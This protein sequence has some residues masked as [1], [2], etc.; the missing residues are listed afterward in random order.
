MQGERA[1]GRGQ[2][3]PH[4][5]MHSGGKGGERTIRRKIVVKDARVE[6]RRGEGERDEEGAEERE[7]EHG[8]VRGRGEGRS[9][10]TRG[11]RSSEKG[12]VK[13]RLRAGER[14]EGRDVVWSPPLRVR[15]S[16]GRSGRLR[17]TDLKNMIA[18]EL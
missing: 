17:R 16:L 7:A 14:E 13:E 1:K 8:A 18:Y 10:A 15:I 3:M 4:E 2:R 5:I 12:R 11:S 9:R 6:V